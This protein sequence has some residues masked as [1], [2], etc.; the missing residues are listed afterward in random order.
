MK[1]LDK[2]K[3]TRQVKNTIGGYLCISPVIIGVLVFTVTPVLLSLFYSFT[4]Y[5]NISPPEF[6]GFDNFVNLWTDEEFLHSLKIT[7]YYTII[8]LPFDIG[9]SFLFGLLMNTKIKAMN[10]FRIL[11]YLPCIVPGLASAK[12]WQDLFNPT[13]NG[14]FNRILMALGLEDPFPF[15][16]HPDTALFS[17]FIMGLFGLGGGMLFWLAGFNGIDNSY[18]EFSALEGANPV[19]NLFYITLPMMSPLLFYKVV[20]NII[21]SLQAY[22]TSLLMTAGGPQGSTNFLGLNIY[23]TGLVEM[24]MGYA[25]AQSWILFILIFLVTTLVFKNQNWVFYAEEQ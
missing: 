9:L 19:Q 10:V 7:I 12:I 11:V 4:R 23:T 15:L 17:M 2:M 18:Y 24:R 21:G 22:G 5:N 16:T 8:T 6:I 14:R 3:L 1:G 13:A 20:M 25:C